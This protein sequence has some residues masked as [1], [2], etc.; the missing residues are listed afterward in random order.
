MLSDKSINDE[1]KD[2]IKM[3][4]KKASFLNFSLDRATRWYER[5]AVIGVLVVNSFLPIRLSL[6]LCYWTTCLLAR[7]PQHRIA[8][9]AVKRVKEQEECERI[10][11]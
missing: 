5:W 4:I 1:I 2:S 8:V 11:A 10:D 3:E 6:R 9:D 7:N